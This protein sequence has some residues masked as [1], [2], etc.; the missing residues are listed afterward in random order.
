MTPII[1][2]THQHKIHYKAAKAIGITQTQLDRYIN[3]RAMV[4][5]AGRVWVV[6][7][8]VTKPGC[9]VDT[10]ASTG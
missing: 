8:Q 9:E 3:Y 4:D 5:D 7:G 2:L 1:E 10:V 6:R